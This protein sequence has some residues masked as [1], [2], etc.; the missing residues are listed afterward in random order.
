MLG[1]RG[2]ESIGRPVA[3]ASAALDDRPLSTKT[4]PPNTVGASCPVHTAAKSIR[5]PSSNMQLYSCMSRPP[6]LSGWV[7][8]ELR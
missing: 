2:D 7:A 3:Q 8:V 4:S 5:P 6:P 1:D